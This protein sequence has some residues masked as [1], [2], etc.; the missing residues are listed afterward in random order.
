MKRVFFYPVMTDSHMLGYCFSFGSLFKLNFCH[1]YE[2]AR[3]TADSCHGSLSNRRTNNLHAD[4]AMNKASSQLTA[5]TTA[6]AAPINRSMTRDHHSPR[7]CCTQ[8]LC[9]VERTGSSTRSAP[10][11]PLHGQ[12][13]N[14]GKK[15]ERQRDHFQRLLPRVLSLSSS[16][17][18]PVPP[19]FLSESRSRTG[20]SS[21]TFLTA[22]LPLL[23][24]GWKS[25]PRPPFH[26]KRRFWNRKSVKICNE[27]AAK[28]D[29]KDIIFDL[30]QGLHFI[31]FDLVQK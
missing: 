6:A 22:S 21:L 28:K 3:Y 29:G 7:Y 8:G 15:S 31:A 26:F 24:T 30:E 13:R 2:T 10:S 12:L 18:I 20:G 5:A 16:R 27:R 14:T 23:S 17:T 9:Q 19:F 4:M 1:Q 25:E 11:T